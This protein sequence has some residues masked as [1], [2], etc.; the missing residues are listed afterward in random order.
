MSSRPGAQK[1]VLGLGFGVR[2]ASV[3]YFVREINCL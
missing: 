1:A 3:N 2:A